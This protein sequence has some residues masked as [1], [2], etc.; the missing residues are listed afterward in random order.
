LKAHQLQKVVCG[1]CRLKEG[2]VN[3]SHVRLFKFRFLGAL[4]YTYT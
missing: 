4:I 3:V 2:I 1:T